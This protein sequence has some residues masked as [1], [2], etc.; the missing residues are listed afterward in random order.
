MHVGR[1]CGF[2]LNYFDHLLIHWNYRDELMVIRTAV[3][4]VCCFGAALQRRCYFGDPLPFCGTEIPE[5]F[6]QRRL[7]CQLNTAIQQ[8]ISS[9]E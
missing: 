5:N 4:N 2:L 6:I 8:K 9:T 3:V 7:N 1:R